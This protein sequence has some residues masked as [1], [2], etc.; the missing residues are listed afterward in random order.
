[1]FIADR[2]SFQI[3]PV[4]ER[5]YEYVK[6]SMD[7][8]LS[9]FIE[10]IS[11]ARA[12]SESLRIRGGGTKDFYGISLIGD[13]LDTRNFA[14]V[15]EYEPTELVL[16]AK[17]GTPLKEIEEIL[18]KNNQILPFEPPHFGPNATFGGCIASGFSGP[19]RAAQGAVRDCVLGIRLLN[20]DGKDLQFG[21]KVMKNVAGFDVSRI[22]T[23]SFGTLG[24]ILEASIKVLPKP[25][26]EQTVFMSIRDDEV[27][28]KMNR[29]AGMAIPLSA[30][31]YDGEK[32]AVRLSGSG[33]AVNAALKKIGGDQDDSTDFWESVRE[34]THPFFKTNGNMFRLSVKS[35]APL[36]ASQ[37]TLIEWNGSVRWVYDGGTIND[38]QDY[39]NQHGGH[40]TLFRG[41]NGNNEI[42][43]LA[44][45]LQTMQLKIKHALDAKGIFGKKRLFLEF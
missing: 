45:A 31:C 28:E 41:G 33:I 35:T 1:M 7:N 4:S 16:T 26:T 2:K 18:A 17:C 30:T 34:Q 23:G 14:G 6:R 10:Q 38:H 43:V 29:L 15:T 40:A 25:E 21:G 37:N 42:S 13:I 36:K 8:Q 32:L 3:F 27:I 22:V 11:E 24:L 44:P 20:C 39:A 9:K 19:R 12:K 5:S